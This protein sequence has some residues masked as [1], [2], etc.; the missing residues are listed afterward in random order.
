MNSAQQCGGA[1]SS[2]LRPQVHKVRR[3]QLNSGSGRHLASH[4]CLR[5]CL[6]A[7]L[8]LLDGRGETGGRGDAERPVVVDG[9]GRR[10]ARDHRRRCCGERGG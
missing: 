5:Q 6:T 9:R 2:D 4:L 7:P 10:A 8:V 1:G 3:W